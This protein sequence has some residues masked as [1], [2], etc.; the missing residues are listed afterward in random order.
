MVRCNKIIISMK[1]PTFSLGILVGFILCA[2]IILGQSIF[3][4]YELNQPD[5]E[6]ILLPDNNIKL[7]SKDTIRVMDFYQLEEEILQDN[8]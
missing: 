5:Y 3:K 8:L 2:F 6:I 1:Q 4:D 7:I